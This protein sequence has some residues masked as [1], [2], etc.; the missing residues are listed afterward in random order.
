MRKATAVKRQTEKKGL[1]VDSEEMVQPLKTV[2]N[3]CRKGEEREQKVSEKI[4]EA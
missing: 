4:K 2:K 1:K 3:K